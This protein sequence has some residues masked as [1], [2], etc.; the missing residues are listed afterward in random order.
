MRSKYLIADTKYLE[1]DAWKVYRDTRVVFVELLQ[2]RD[3]YPNGNRDT[4]VHLSLTEM[5][6]NIIPNG[7]RE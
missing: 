5:G 3:S 1:T 2:D 7:N 4:I 6:D